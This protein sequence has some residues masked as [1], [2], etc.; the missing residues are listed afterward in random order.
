[1]T[2]EMPKAARRQPQPPLPRERPRP[3]AAA[4]QIHLSEPTVLA[5]LLAAH[6]L[7]SLAFL[8]YVPLGVG[9]D[10]GN[11]LLF[12]QTLAGDGPPSVWRWGLPVL[13][14][15]AD[16]RAADGE[17][18]FE[19]RHA[20][21]EVHQPPLYYVL[22][23]PLYRLFGVA[24]LR[25]AA[26]LL[27]LVLVWLTWR[28]TR[29]VFAPDLALGAAAVVA[30]LP[31]Q[32]FLDTRLGNDGLTAVL[33]TL[34]CW[35]WAV[36]LRDGP[37][38]RAGLLAGAGIGLALL[39]KQNSLVLLP[40]TVV[41][42]ALSGWQTGRWRAVAG[43]W[44]ATLAAAALLAGWWYLRNR[45]VYGD[46]MAQGA[47]DQRFLGHRMTPAALAAGFAAMGRPLSYGG[48]C[49]EWTARSFV[50]FLSDTKKLLPQGVYPVQMALLGVG[51][52]GAARAVARRA[53]RAG[54]DPAVTTSL[55]LAAAL[56]LLILV[57]GQFLRHYFQAQGRY[58]F[59]L[60]PAWGLLLAGGP[61]RLFRAGSAARRYGLLAAPLWLGIM[62]LMVTVVYLPGLFHG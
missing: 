13:D 34:V 40:L 39:T 4:R 6:L 15:G 16:D 44:L 47:F 24:A 57:Y 27:G 12:I 11:H 10:E 48:Y 21:F 58:L 43:Q 9:P 52:A 37:S 55:L 45:V 14:T 23:A 51:L 50:L 17:L 38:A 62:A 19:A 5:L 28:L 59:P 36:T 42:A 31:M 22:S 32:A 29:T 53:R 2:A 26:V 33:W 49:L 30:L 25:L 61:S 20:N 3:P 56:V 18:A 60:L 7:L 35:R 41:L 54:P 8:A 1:M 46:P